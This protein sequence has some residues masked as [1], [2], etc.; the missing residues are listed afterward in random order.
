MV[1]IVNH[2]AR[3]AA[4]FEDEARR[5]SGV[6]GSAVTR[7][8]H[9]GSTA[10]PGI[11]AKPIIDILLEVSSLPAIDSRT[12]ALEALSYEAKGEFGI[13]GRRYFRRDDASGVRTHHLHAFRCGAPEVDRHLAF[14]DYLRAFPD[15]AADYGAL[16]RSLVE[17]H[18]DSSE[19]YVEG[20]SAF[21]LEQ[22]ARALRWVTERKA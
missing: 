7:I 16:K 9:I 14:R 10:I 4:R 12:S 22:Q 13:P 15:V 5:I 3:W 19:R 2:D 1:Q 8:H 18:P 20:K 11:P 6:L 17:A 21:V